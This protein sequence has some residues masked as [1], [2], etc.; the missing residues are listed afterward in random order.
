MNLQFSAGSVGLCGSGR[1]IQPGPVCMI[2]RSDR[3]MTLVGLVERVNLCI[4]SWLY[5]PVEIAGVIIGVP[6]LY[7]AGMSAA[8]AQVLKGKTKM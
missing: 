1:G 6:E 4:I 5:L 7:V 2:S 8:Q 3:H